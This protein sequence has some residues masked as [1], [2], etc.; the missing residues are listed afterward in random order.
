MIVLYARLEDQRLPDHMA[1]KIHR[2]RTGVPFDISEDHGRANVLSKGKYMKPLYDKEDLARNTY[3]YLQWRLTG[4][5][6]VAFR[7]GC[8]LRGCSEGFADVIG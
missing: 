6:D 1:C 8:T 5:M 4:T 2:R 3:M 7:T